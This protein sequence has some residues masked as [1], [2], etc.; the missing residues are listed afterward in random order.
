V[1]FH[2]GLARAQFARDLLGEPP[3]HH[4][5]HHV[6]LPRRERGKPAVQSC[7]LRTLRVRVAGAGERLVNGVE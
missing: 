7:H 1:R 6:P 5:R 3:C 2:R 4:K